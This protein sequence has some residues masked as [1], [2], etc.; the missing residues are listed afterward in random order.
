MPPVVAIAQLPQ[1]LVG[2]GRHFEFAYHPVL[3]GE[4]LDRVVVVLTDVT[5]EVERQRALAEQHEF[6]VLVDQF[7][8]DRRAFLDFWR[9]ASTLVRRV[10]QD[11][12]GLPSDALR[13]DVHTLKGNARFFGLTRV[14]SLCHALEDAMRERGENLL[15]SQE[16]TSL[17]EVWEALRRRIDPIIEGATAFLQVSEEEY[18]R[19]VDALEHRLPHAALQDIVRGLRLEPTAWRL[20]RARDMLFSAC[21]KLGKTPPK[22]SLEHNDLRLSP[23]RWSP[24]WSVLPHVI[25]NAADHGIETDD[26]RRNLGKTLPANVRL[27]T[28]LKNGEFYVEVRDDGRGIDWDAVRETAAK[29]NLPS[30][31]REELEGAL[32][33]EGFSLKD[34]VSDVSGRG[35]GLAAV[36]NVVAAMRGRIE[37]QSEKG[38]GTTWR[39]HFPA[40]KVLDA[41]DDNL[42]SHAWPDRSGETLTH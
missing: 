33:T 10:V 25:S 9:E 30:R 2:R 11:P 36:Q 31:T 27:A 19:L 24:F 21:Q 40:G 20:G 29:R 26:E 4:M 7:V 35:V 12:K 5:A 38:R 6:S 16:R 13:R 1:T 41:E 8:R 32:F 15:T 37:I 22:V 28:V 18:R 34:A 39:F 17:A 14:S 23:G 3:N 42:D